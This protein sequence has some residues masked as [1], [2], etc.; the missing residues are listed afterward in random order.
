MLIYDNISK[1]YTYNIWRRDRPT[2]AGIL[3]N[4][5][6]DRIAACVEHA[7]SFVSHF[8]IFCCPGNNGVVS[9]IVQNSWHPND[10]G[11]SVL[12]SMVGVNRHSINKWPVRVVLRSAPVTTR[13][14]LLPYNESEFQRLPR[15]FMSSFPLDGSYRLLLHSCEVDDGFIGK[16]LSGMMMLNISKGVLTMQIGSSCRRRVGACASTVDEA[17]ID[18]IPHWMACVCSVVG[19]KIYDVSVG[20][21]NGREFSFGITIRIEQCSYP[22]WFCNEDLFSIKIST[23][24]FSTAT[25]QWQCTMPFVQ[26]FE[27]FTSGGINTP[28]ERV[29]IQNHIYDKKISASGNKSTKPR[30]GSL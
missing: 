8:G 14:R 28:P 16:I 7:E 4:A 9:H 29:E 27:R 13:G 17:F 2:Y 11:D 1:T 12:H 30:R 25:V 10:V 15:K 24:A 21:G 26:R 3:E 19:L 20:G 5:D 18:D 22:L 23:E 6:D